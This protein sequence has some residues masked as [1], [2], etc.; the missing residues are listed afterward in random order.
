MNTLKLFIG[1]LTI[2]LFSSTCLGQNV[3]TREITKN[4]RTKLKLIGKVKTLTET[5]F[6]A[7]EKSGVSPREVQDKHVSFFNK[8]GR[9]I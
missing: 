1:L 9:P 5:N 4:D 7:G 8:K 6:G 3:N 2:S